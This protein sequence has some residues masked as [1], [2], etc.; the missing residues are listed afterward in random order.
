MPRE[1]EVTIEDVEEA[2]VGRY[3]R[4]APPST[5]ATTTRARNRH[6]DTNRSRVGD[7]P[8]T[9]AD[10]VGSAEKREY[11]FLEQMALR[12]NASSRGGE[13]VTAS[14]S[15]FARRRSFK[16]G[17]AKDWDVPASGDGMGAIGKTSFKHGYAKHWDVPVSPESSPVGGTEGAG[18]TSPPPRDVFASIDAIGALAKGD[19]VNEK[20][21]EREITTT[22]KSEDAPKERVFEYD[23]D[24]RE[25]EREVEVPVASFDA[26]PSSP[27]FSEA[28]FATP[29]KATS[30]PRGEERAAAMKEDSWSFPVVGRPREEEEVKQ[31]VRFPAREKREGGA[32][33]G[34]PLKGS[35]LR[36]TPLPWSPSPPRTPLGSR[37]PPNSPASARTR[38]NLEAQMR[39]AA[40]WASREETLI[41]SGEHKKG[42]N[43][44]FSA[45]RGLGAKLYRLVI[46]AGHLKA[47]V[48]SL[49]SA[50]VERA[51][52]GGAKLAIVAL[53]A[54]SGIQVAH[55]AL[56]AFSAALGE[57]F[58]RRIAVPEA[59]ARRAAPIL[60]PATL[61]SMSKS[62]SLSVRGTVGDVAA[63]VVPPLSLATFIGALWPIPGGQIVGDARE[64]FGMINHDVFLDAPAWVNGNLRHLGPVTNALS[65]AA[66]VELMT[67]GDVHAENGAVALTLASIL[68]FAVKPATNRVT[69]NFR[70]V[71]A[72]SHLVFTL[73]LARAEFAWRETS[74]WRR[75]LAKRQGGLE[76]ATSL[77]RTTGPL[78]GLGGFVR[79]AARL[80][81]LRGRDPP[82]RRPA[83]RASRARS[84]DIDDDDDEFL[85]R[86]VQR[87]PVIGP[88]LIIL[89][90]FVF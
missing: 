74:V 61:A 63:L 13:A 31:E 57:R 1:E 25:K 79:A 84:I 21:V 40:T 43:A 69:V 19:G 78:A 70:E 71:R 2:P 28:S 32:L 89:S 83:R 76:G 42:V 39:R 67:T 81:R 16:H 6:H 41:Q 36:D 50:R 20:A 46:A 86:V 27:N 8:T 87:L 33:T 5:T 55:N 35:P 65:L 56:L 9:R 62:R 3:A 54:N 82:A 7:D 73:S 80:P 10:G 22:R 44:I 66:A 90:G 60:L 15:G 11:T 51:H 14:P 29:T 4:D 45:G 85:D 88:V 58:M 64:H 68:S 48:K 53:C 75:Y 72:A 59:L 30:K 52:G 37:I 77:D 38:K 34:S 49:D 12:E 26:K 47:F 17:R 18:T 23:F 24:W